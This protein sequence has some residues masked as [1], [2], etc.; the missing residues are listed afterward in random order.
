MREEKMIFN[1][2]IRISASLFLFLF[3]IFFFCFCFVLT[4]AKRN[5]TEIRKN[6]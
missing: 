6:K 5:E 4:T 2:I 3:L 1:M